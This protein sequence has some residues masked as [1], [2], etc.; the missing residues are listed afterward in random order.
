MMGAPNPEIKL[1]TLRTC[2]ELIEQHGAL[3]VG[4]LMA[5]GNL[6]DSLTRNTVAYGVKLGYLIEGP[7]P[8]RL[9]KGNRLKTY[10]RTK[11]RFPKEITVVKE[12]T[13]GRSEFTPFRHWQ[14]EAFFGPAPRIWSSAGKVS[15]RIIRQEMSVTDEVEIV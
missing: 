8:A 5:M 9:G 1:R 6:R 14:D 3:S 7:K 10:L 11:K 2:C 12:T 13:N 15:A 4:D